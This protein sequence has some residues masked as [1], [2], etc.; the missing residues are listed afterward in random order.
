MV[1]AGDSRGGKH[2]RFELRGGGGGRGG[3]RALNDEAP[4]AWALGAS[5]YMVVAGVGFEP[6]T[7][8]L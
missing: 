5:S 7:F 6:T 1:H 2:R 3:D 8:R 4:G